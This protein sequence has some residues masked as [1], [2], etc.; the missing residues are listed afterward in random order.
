MIGIRR[1]TALAMMRA[2]RL[3]LAGFLKRGLGSAAASCTRLVAGE[4]GRALMEIVPARRLGPEYAGPELG[5]VEIDLHH[6][7]LRP[8]CAT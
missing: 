6:P 8:E 7:L 3:C 5:D 2:R 4:V 1:S